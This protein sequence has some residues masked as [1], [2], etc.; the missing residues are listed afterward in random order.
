M[1]ANAVVLIFLTKFLLHRL[2]SD[3]FGLLRYV[4]AVEASLLFLDLGL[5]G[6]LNRFVARLLAT[7]DSLRVNA[8]VTLSG[9]LFLGLGVVAGLVMVVA[10]SFLPHLVTD[11]T[12]ELYA[13]GATLMAYI[14]ATL[15]LRFW[16]YA[17]RGL[18]FGHQRHDV[19]NVIQCVAVLLRAGL[20]VTLLL[21]TE[22]PKLAAVGLAFVC[23]AALETSGLW[24][25][26]KRIFPPM[27][28]SAGAITRDLVKDF[29]G[30]SVY[31]LLM[32]ITTML[33]VN[34]P[35]L[36][37]GKLYGTEAVAFISLPLLVLN[38]IQNFAGGFAFALIPVAGKFG[39]LKDR[40]ALQTII[41]R[42]TK[43]CALFAFPVGVIATV[44]GRPLFDWFEDGF[45]WT[46]GLLAIMVVPILMRTTQRVSYSVLMGAGSVK[47][48]ALGQIGVAAAVIV[49][50]VVF[51]QTAG[52]KIFGIALGTAV[53]VL[54]FALVFQPAYACRQVGLRWSQYLPQA[55]LRVVGCTAVT[56][57]VA[58][59]LRALVYPDGLLMIVIEGGICMAVYGGC[60]WRFA[61]SDKDRDQFLGLFR[62]E[63]PS[64]D[65][66]EAPSEMSEPDTGSRKSERA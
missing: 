33:I 51:A 40:A 43:Y 12:A 66:A 50:S 59:L 37:A 60:A 54:G 57:L 15:M 35:T 34:S 13:G 3:Q 4:L 28:P 52:M 45:G 29:F 11:G 48:L 6:T 23:A 58:L 44:F 25:A 39:V 26:A 63:P 30:F 9:L 18:L 10:G 42:G 64:T 56:A 21:A 5:G 61:L 8:V 41:L 2:G 53:P 17:A 1:T 46:W 65:P 20:I 27:R 47:W 24:I 14:G 32:A 22:V 38:Q 7:N 55:Y 36:I 62:R 16:G 31:V 19:V 49:L